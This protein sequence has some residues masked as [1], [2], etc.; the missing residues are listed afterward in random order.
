MTRPR[1]G[2]AR[3]V[4]VSYVLVRAAMSMLSN[5][6]MVIAV[7]SLQ[8]P[9]I[10]VLR[11][12]AQ[13]LE[14]ARSLRNISLSATTDS[15]VRVVGPQPAFGSRSRKTVCAPM[16]AGCGNGCP[17]MKFLARSRSICETMKRKR[18]RKREM[19]GT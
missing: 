19:W 6:S 13:A 3:S 8:H 15:V 12:Q 17:S 7:C 9:R 5:I 2:G 11:R 10:V 1:D 18:P 14:H 4:M 16:K